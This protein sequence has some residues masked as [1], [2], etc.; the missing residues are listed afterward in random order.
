M[1]IV[2][3][4]IMNWYTDFQDMRLLELDTMKTVGILGHTLSLSAF[5][6]LENIYRSK[7]IS[8]MKNIYHRGAICILKKFKY[9]RRMN[10][11]K[12]EKI[13]II[14]KIHTFKSNFRHSQPKITNM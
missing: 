6:K 2:N 3:S 7:T 11:K 13:L 12:G 10:L 14:S 9:L 5:I 8:L 4:S 1:N